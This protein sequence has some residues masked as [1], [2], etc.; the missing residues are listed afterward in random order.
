MRTRSRLAKR[1]IDR[2]LPVTTLL[3]L[4]EQW[5]I[6]FLPWK[7]PI[8]LE[9]ITDFDGSRLFFYLCPKKAL[10]DLER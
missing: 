7:P 1:R 10:D 8:Q 6:G 4:D 5:I 3:G 9:G 2:C